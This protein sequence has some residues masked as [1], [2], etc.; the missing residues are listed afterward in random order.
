MIVPKKKNQ[1]KE[2]NVMKVTKA[3]IKDPTLT[4]RELWKL[5]WM[6]A[7]TANRARREVAQNGTKIPSIADI[8]KLDIDIVK[9]WL[10]EIQRRFADKEELKKIRAQEISQII[11]ENTARYT[12]FKWDITDDEWWLKKEFSKD[13]INNLLSRMHE[14]YDE[15]GNAGIDTENS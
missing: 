1:L 6:W 11:K 5:T 3:L 9:K 7:T 15:Q 14:L 2:K 8:C 4:S 10:L 12:L 13:Q